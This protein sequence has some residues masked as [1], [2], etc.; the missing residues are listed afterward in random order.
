MIKE[1][2]KDIR[3]G[4]D[5]IVRQI[6]I[7]IDQTHQEIDII[8]TEITNHIPRLG[9]TE[10]TKGRRTRIDQDPSLRIGIHTGTIIVIADQHLQVI[11]REAT[12]HQIVTRGQIH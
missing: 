6:I 12:V 7:T 10:E 11:S 4:H 8:T 3:T 1:I 5:Q 9:M 2:I